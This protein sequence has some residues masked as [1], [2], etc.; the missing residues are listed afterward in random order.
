MSIGGLIGA[1]VG[2]VIGYIIGG[3]YGA[4][5]GISLG[6]SLG[7]YVDPITPDIPSV[8]GPDQG[9]QV[10]S[11]E[12]GTPIAD[13]AGTAKIAGHLLCYGGER[14]DPVYGEAGG[15]KGGG[16]GS[17]PQITGYKYYMSWAVGILAGEA[18]TLYAIYKNDDVVW[19]G[20]L[21]CP[22]SGGEETIVLTEMGSATFYFGTD[23]HALNAKVGAL[24]DDPAL[25]IPYRNL[26]WCFFDDCFIGNYNRAPT[27]KFVVSKI[28]EYSFSDKHE[29]QVYDCN[30]AHIQW[31][32][33]HDLIGLSESWLHSA[34]FAT[35]ALT[36]WSES[37]G[38]SVLFD[39]Q[40]SALSYLESVNA[41]VDNILRYGIDGKFHPKLIRD[42]YEVGDLPI[43]DEDVMLEEPTFN[44]KSWIDTLNEMK[45]QYSEIIG[46][47]EIPPEFGPLW[48]A[49]YNY[50]GNLGTGNTVS[51]PIF[52]E[53]ETTNYV[54]LG[55]GHENTII[56]SSDLTLWGTGLNNYGQLGLG[57]IITRYSFVQISEDSWQKVCGGYAHNMF[58]KEDGTLWGAGYNSD[59]GQL[60]LGDYVNR[61]VLTQCLTGVQAVATGMYHT[62][63][64]KGET[65]WGVG[66]NSGG[67]LGLNNTT[68]KSTFEQE[69]GESTWKSIA[70]GHD[71]TIALRTNDSLWGTGGNFNGQ[72]GL[73]DNAN[74]KVF[75]QEVSLSSWLK[76]ACRESYTI[77]IKSDGTLWGTGKNNHHQLGLGDTADRWIFTQIGVD[78]D[79]SDVF[80]AYGS[81][82]VMKFDGALWGFGYNQH[83]V[84]GLNHSNEVQAPTDLSIKALQV[85]CGASHTVIIKKA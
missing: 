9:V 16:G 25:N 37:R 48:G 28:P 13:L 77:A 10:M 17:D 34:D 2:G 55:C 70:C 27:M 26:C 74:R 11:S 20:E 5:Y 52:I 8:G 21:D 40:Q 24:I 61:D 15:G 76:V 83:S 30:P 84:L 45:V 7:M 81:T 38:L 59:Y 23:D 42:D 73:N 56:I 75:T 31:F 44:R 67:Q 19:E 47:G 41:H 79:W 33:L 72:L 14:A 62:I 54:E 29:I 39:R 85:A 12:I 71:F 36:L 66:R 58:L 82:V 4:L 57:D 18:D 43:I 22:A 63:V 68:N 69:V 6:F 49:G 46:A 60:G 64:L 80:C 35:A 50:Y 3:P 65:L 51:S 32:I 1:V 53:L 78:S